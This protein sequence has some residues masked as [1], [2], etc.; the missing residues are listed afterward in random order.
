MRAMILLAALALPSSAP[1]TEREAPT[2]R[3]P[4]VAKSQQPC[5]R[6][7]VQMA[8][9]LNGGLTVRNLGELPPARLEHTVLREFDGCPIP[10]V[11]REG[12]GASG[13]GRR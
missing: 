2:A 7:T 3:T 13:I 1:A 8:N 9:R 6:A 11:V 12:I 4:A 10:A 5:Q